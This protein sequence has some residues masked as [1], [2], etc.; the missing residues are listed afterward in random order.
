MAGGQ[1]ALLR[2]WQVRAEEVLFRLML[3]IKVYVPMDFHRRVKRD[4]Q[5]R[6]CATTFLISVQL[7]SL[8][9]WEFLVPY[10]HT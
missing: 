5:K 9:Q 7:Q 1:A 8:P 3:C 6:V 2:L 10:F 4:A